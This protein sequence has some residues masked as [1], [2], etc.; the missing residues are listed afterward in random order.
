MLLCGHVLHTSCLNR[1]MQVS[2]KDKAR[3][4][5]YGCN[6]A[7]VEDA[8]SQLLSLASQTQSAAGSQSADVPAVVVDV[9]ENASTL[10]M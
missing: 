9:D 3:A 2:G 8:E 7:G 10:V 1:W 6:P 5:P 4:C